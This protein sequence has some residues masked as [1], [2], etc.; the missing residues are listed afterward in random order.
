MTAL[1]V[2]LAAVSAVVVAAH[3]TPGLTSVNRSLAPPEYLPSS[4]GAL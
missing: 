4:G 1:G 3:I 2:V